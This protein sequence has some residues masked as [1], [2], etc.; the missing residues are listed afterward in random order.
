MRVL[1]DFTMILTLPVGSILHPFAHQAECH[2]QVNN[3]YIFPGMSFGAVC[4]QAREIPESFF[5][6]AA[7]AV[8]NSLGSLATKTRGTGKKCFGKIPGSSSSTPP[9][10]KTWIE[11]F[12]HKQ[13]K[14]SFQWGELWGVSGFGV[15]CDSWL[16]GFFQVMKSCNWIWW[17]PNGIESKRPGETSHLLRCV[18]VSD[19]L[20]VTKLP[21]WER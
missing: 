16:L 7:E 11:H 8:A 15:F 9:P 14:S 21:I 5:M 13:R 19:V 10:K 20:G 1:H 2:D 4:C 18:W 6:A 17:C 3:V 12:W